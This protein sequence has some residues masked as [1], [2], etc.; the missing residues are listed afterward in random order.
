MKQLNP[1]DVHAMKNNPLNTRSARFLGALAAA[2]LPMAPT[3]GLADDAAPSR[4]DALLNFEFSNEYLTPRG[5]IVQ[6]KGLT[7]QQLALGFVNIYKDDTSS[8]INGVT[9][10]P[11]VWA[12]FASR[13]VGT[14]SGGYLAK[15]RTDF[16]EVDPIAGVSFNFWKRFTWSETYTAFCMQIENIGTSQHLDSKLAFNDTDFLKAFA[17]H[18][19][20]EYWQELYAKSTDADLPWKISGKGT[21]P[22]SSYY[23]EIGVAPSYTISSINLKLE[24]PCRVLLPDSRFYGDY[25]APSSTVGLYE[26]GVKGTYPLSHFPKGFGNW[27]LHAGVRWVQ[28]MDENLVDL[29]QFN[30]PGKPTNHEWQGYAGV[31]IFF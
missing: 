22:G 27:S 31:S 30:A 10:T 29:N 5:M 28:F 19:Y 21:G 15:P 11:G 9:L 26:L 2:A 7:Y 25:Y 4:V 6:D 13:G 3:I 12:D 16:V 20:F 17:L 24:A 18:P 23:F 14:T 1:D 8:F